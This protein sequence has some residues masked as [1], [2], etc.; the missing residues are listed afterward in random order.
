LLV[1]PFSGLE[2]RDMLSSDIDNVPAPTADPLRVSWTTDQREGR[3]EHRPA[4]YPA[5]AQK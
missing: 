2:S 3:R 5:A 4:A 1:R